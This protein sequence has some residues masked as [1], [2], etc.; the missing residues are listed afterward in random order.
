ML[1]EGQS[2]AL[3]YLPSPGWTCEHSSAAVDELSVT[4]LCLWITNLT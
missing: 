4:V 2:L 3:Q 1:E